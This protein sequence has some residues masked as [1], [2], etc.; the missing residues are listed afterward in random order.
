VVGICKYGIIKDG[1]FFELVAENL[2]KILALDLELLQGVV[3]NC[4]RIKAEIVT[5]DEK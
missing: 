3:I 4:C 5:E 1:E 2:E